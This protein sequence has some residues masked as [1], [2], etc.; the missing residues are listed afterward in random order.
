MQCMVK[1]WTR[2]SKPERLFL[3][4][5]MCEMQNQQRKSPKLK[6]KLAQ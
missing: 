3:L 6:Q 4:N 5:L 2:L 1:N